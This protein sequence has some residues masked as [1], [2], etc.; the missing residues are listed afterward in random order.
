[1]TDQSEAPW[2][3]AAGPA[4]ASRESTTARLWRFMTECTSVIPNTLRN[5]SS[6]TFMGPGLFPGPGAACGNAVDI[7][8]WKVTL[9]SIFCITW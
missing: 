9:P 3:A 5:L 1:V 4:A 2:P 8:V 7:A 6:D